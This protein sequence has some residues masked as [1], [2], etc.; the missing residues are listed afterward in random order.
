MQKKY[1]TLYISIPLLVVMFLLIIGCNNHKNAIEIL[2]IKPQD[3]QNLI[4]ISG[5]SFY[6]MSQMNYNADICDY[7]IMKYNL[8]T[9]EIIEV[10]EIKNL[11]TWSDTYAFVNEER[12]FS[13]FGVVEGDNA[14]NIHTA[15]NAKE[16]SINV[17]SKDSFFPPLVQSVSVNQN[18]FVEFQPQQLEDGSYRY[19]IRKADKNGN[20]KEIVSKD[21]KADYSGSMIVDVCAYSDII[22]TFEYEAKNAY[23]CSYDL[24]G[25]QITKESIDL[26]NE[27]LN[28]PDEFTGDTETMWSIDVINGYYFFSTLNGKYLVLH[29]S[30][31]IY[32]KVDLLTTNS[33]NSNISLIKNVHPLDENYKKIIIYDYNASKLF[34]FNTE[35]GEL[36]NLDFD[37]KG[38]IHCIT[39]GKQLIY[40]ND[41]Q[42]VYYI[43]DVYAK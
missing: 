35:K 40:L 6:Y 26:V 36:K 38:A 37:L 20:N 28:T 21:R 39:D 14:Y 4:G 15:L 18:C 42:E 13:T 34:Y 16:K 30:G 29:K 10:G 24:A 31:E 27:F 19:C 23:V 17:L 25:N 1:S 33:V 11:S 22:Y 7:K 41:K 32:S 3:A 9:D 8:L 2:N 43:A 5:N 12:F